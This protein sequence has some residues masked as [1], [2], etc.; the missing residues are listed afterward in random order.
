MSDRNYIMSLER[1]LKILEIFSTSVDRLTLTEIAELSGMNKTSTK[2]FLHTLSKLGYL[3]KDENKRYFL[4][5]KVLS[6]GFGFLNNFDLRAICKDQ[7]DALSLKLNTTV[8]LTILD[9]LDVVYIYRKEKVRLLNYNLY[10]GSRLPA[11]CTSAGKALLAGLEDAELENRIGR[12]DL[13]PITSRTI[14]DSKLLLKNIFEVREKGYSICNRE[15]SM[16]LYA[17]AAPII[18]NDGNVV[19]AINVTMNAKDRTK[20]TERTIIDELIKK[21][22]LISNMIGY[23]GAY[24]IFNMGQ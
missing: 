2:R 18:N 12:M 9:D 7:I 24:P 21:G 20:K 13:K 22:S 14:I 19:A 6:L 4:T 1:A 3:D 23:I 5:V 8:N 17:M 16:D 11:Y 10:D 15:L